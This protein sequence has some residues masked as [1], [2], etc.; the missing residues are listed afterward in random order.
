MLHC[1]TECSIKGVLFVKLFKPIQDG[2]LR[3]YSQMWGQKGPL[4]KYMSHLSYN[5]ETWQSYTSP[6]TSYLTYQSRDTHVE[7]CC[8]KHF[9]LEVKKFCYVKK[10]R[11]RLHF[12]T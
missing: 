1:I 10:Y 7:F 6:N 2:L 3:C 8:H 5:D 4:P 11:Y 9:L 12:D